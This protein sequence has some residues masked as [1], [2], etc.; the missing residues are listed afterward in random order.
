MPA[1]QVP[2]AVKVT[3]GQ[4]SSRSWGAIKG[5]AMCGGGTGGQCGPSDGQGAGPAVDV[6]PAGHCAPQGAAGSGPCTRDPIWAAAAQEP[7]ER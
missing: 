4:E 6:Q 1:L 3:P 5:S 7:Q 2:S